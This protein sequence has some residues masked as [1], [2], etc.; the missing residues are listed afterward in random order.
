MWEKVLKLGVESGQ[1]A[2]FVA[3]P[4][5]VTVLL[6]ISISSYREK[7]AIDGIFENLTN[8]L[9]TILFNYMRG[10]IHLWVW[11]SG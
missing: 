3:I 7:W 1:N 8:L 10:N 9:F 5:L 6:V 11:E 4:T 2:D